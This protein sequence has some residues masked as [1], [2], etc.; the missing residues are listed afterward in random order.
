MSPRKLILTNYLCPGDIV[1]LTATVRALHDAYPGEYLT[2]VRTSCPA[3]WEHNPYI[4]P[5]DDRDPEVTT[6]AMHYPLI[7]HCRAPYHFIHGF[8]QYLSEQLGRPIPLTT[9]RGDIHLSDAERGWM[10]QVAELGHRGPF[11]LMLAGGKFDYTAK[12]WNPMFYQRV[13]DYFR[14]RLQFVQVGERHH[15]HPRLS[16]VINLV[17]KTSLRQFVRLMHHASGVVCP[18]TF[19]MHLSAAMPMPGGHI[20]PCVVIAGGRE[21]NHWEQYPGHQFLH[22]IGTLD[23]CSQGGCWK[24]RCQPVG[25]GDQKDRDL[26]P[27][28][29]IVSADLRIPRCMDLIQPEDVIRAIERYVN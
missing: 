18:V 3:I 17:G 6:I 10:S 8:A 23:C 11:W 13:V 4:T 16:G 22:T 27:R 7:H 9:F 12:W 24:S 20:R 2:D 28:P 5:L 26:C 15:W 1:V 25:D 19:A 14:G 29:V 21:P